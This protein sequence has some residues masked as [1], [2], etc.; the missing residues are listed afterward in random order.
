MFAI[1]G[2]K[3]MYRMIFIAGLLFTSLLFTSQAW[4]QCLETKAVNVVQG[5]FSTLKLVAANEMFES[6]KLEQSSTTKATIIHFW[7]PW[8]V[9]CL[10]ELP[11]LDKAMA[12]Q[13]NI[14]VIPVN[15]DFINKAEG[16]DL[17]S[18]LGIEQLPLLFDTHDLFRKLKLRGLPATAVI[19]ADRTE[20]KLVHGAISWG[21]E[22][23]V[24]ELTQS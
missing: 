10:K 23:I 13:K 22:N 18:K 4:S 24:A 9:P 12:T 15:I 16:R 1:N 6:I 17:F 11:A 14:R 3:N 2:R 7:A 20:M 21:C 8:C 19:S 5:D